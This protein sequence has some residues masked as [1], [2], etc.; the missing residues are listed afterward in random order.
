M[1]ARPKQ[2]RTSLSFINWW[3]LNVH[4]RWRNP[5]RLPYEGSG[6]RLDWGRG[7]VHAKSPSTLRDDKLQLYHNFK[8]NLDAPLAA[9][10]YK[11]SRPG[12][13]SSQ[14]AKGLKALPWDG[15]VE[16]L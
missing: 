14:S 12:N 15:M 11:K 3:T 5:C 16:I 1:L 13:R 10:C 6:A 8:R 4:G 2:L 7:L 9:I